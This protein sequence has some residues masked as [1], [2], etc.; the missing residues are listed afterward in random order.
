MVVVLGWVVVVGAIVLLL[1]GESLPVD[2]LGFDEEHAPASKARATT[3]AASAARRR[4][5]RRSDEW[6]LEVV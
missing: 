1:V 3:H 2:T 4:G 6:G 5:I